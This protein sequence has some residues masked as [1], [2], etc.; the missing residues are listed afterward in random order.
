MPSRR[1]PTEAE[2]LAAR[3]RPGAGLLA[4]DAEAFV[5]GLARADPIASGIGPDRRPTPMCCK[6]EP[7]KATTKDPAEH[8][9]DCPWRA[10]VRWTEQNP[11]P[12]GAVE[13]DP[14]GTDGRR[15]YN[16]A[17]RGP[18]G[19]GMAGPAGSDQ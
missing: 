2:K 19:P 3:V 15:M 7:C 11:K 10:A 9:A 14:M 18:D 6:Y 16:D 8:H 4:E 17:R 13:V 12:D 5:R 1:A